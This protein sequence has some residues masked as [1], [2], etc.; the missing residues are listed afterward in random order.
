MNC[1]A[2]KRYNE[3]LKAP[4]LLLRKMHPLHD[5]AHNTPD[6]RQRKRQRRHFTSTSFTALP[7]DLQTSI[8]AF[9]TPQ[10]LLAAYTHLA[11]SIT[12]T[13]L[14]PACFRTHLLLDTRT[15]NPLPTLSPAAFSLLTRAPSLTIRYSPDMDKWACSS[16]FSTASAR[17]L[18]N[19]T[20]V[21]SVVVGCEDCW[22]P[23]ADR[24]MPV[25][26]L[27]DFLGQPAG[28]TNSSSNAGDVDNS[29]CSVVSSQPLP[30][31]TSLTFSDKFYCGSG[32]GR[33]DTLVVLL[34]LRHLELKFLCGW[35]RPRLTPLLALPAL[36]S[37]TC[38]EW[39]YQ[40]GGRPADA[41]CVRHS[42]SEGCS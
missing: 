37:V 42:R 32:T 38:T 11:H 7:T 33:L 3:L 15:I 31:L 34:S 22:I 41:Q 39:T 6:D 29:G 35:G 14:T 5:D 1:L 21:R 16:F 8:F 26:P 40:V 2:R 4:P 36:Q 20:C 18:L 19:F 17:S 28:T 13:A 27:Q 12:H 9:L 25:T 24:N 10:H 23:V 30:H